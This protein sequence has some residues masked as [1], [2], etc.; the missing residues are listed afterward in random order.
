MDGRP[1]KRRM[2]F[3]HEGNE[4]NADGSSANEASS[5]PAASLSESRFG[6][7]K[8]LSSES[9]SEPSRNRANP[10]S[11][12]PH[13]SSF[14]NL[15]TDELLKKLRPKYETRML[16]AGST[17]RRLQDII[18]NI[19]DRKSL[20]VRRV[21]LDTLD[22]CFPN[23]FHPVKISEAQRTLEHYSSVCIPFPEPMARS[24]SKLLL[25]YL[26]PTNINVTGSFSRKTALLLDGK[27]TIDVAVTMP[28][29]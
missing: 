26:K 17:L 3:S 8:S 25:E 16:E 11:S 23:P 2:H 18:R 10:S 21:R 29:V 20:I 14:F 7:S 15:Q 4:G 22:I 6:V 5:E 12:S 9:L 1:H 13:H 27:V 28:A 24:E 19:P